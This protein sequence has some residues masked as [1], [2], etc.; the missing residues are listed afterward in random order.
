MSTKSRM[1]ELNDDEVTEDF[2]DVDKPIQGQNYCCL[3]FVSPEKV[4]AKKEDYY[5]NQFFKKRMQLFSKKFDEKF[6]KLLEGDGETVDRAL[7]SKLHK[8]FLRETAEAAEK[9]MED[10][11]DFK[12]ANEEAIE[13]NFHQ[14]NDLQTSIRGVK[15]RGTYNTLREAQIRAKV[16]QRMDPSFHIFVG[17]VGYWLPWDPTADKIENQEY[18][19]KELNEI[20]KKYKTNEAKRDMFYEEQKRE[21]KQTKL[22]KEL[23]KQLQK[24]DAPVMII[25]GDD[26]KEASAAPSVVNV[27][28]DREHD[29]QSEE[30][31]EDNKHLE[32]LMMNATSKLAVGDERDDMVEMSDEVD[33][34]NG[35]DPWMARKLEKG[36]MG[37]TVD[38]YENDLHDPLDDDE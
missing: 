30:N 29:H 17:Q 28:N 34:L 21:R 26:E 24:K 22:Q 27:N 13:N 32:G 20:V 8:R 37:S 15:V 14:E 5:F 19:N 35:M 16:L 3:S 23:E 10:F 33:G 38:S 18:N 2:L 7:V 11:A 25:K 1:E 6:E 36:G 12:Y 9:C 4:L 31:M